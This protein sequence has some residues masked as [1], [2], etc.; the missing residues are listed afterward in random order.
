MPDTNLHPTF[1]A[2]LAPLT[3]ERCDGYMVVSR[4]RLPKSV[5]PPYRYD[6]HYDHFDRENDATEFYGEIES[7]RYNDTREA[8]CI[9][10]CVRGVPLGAKK[11]LP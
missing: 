4:E 9:V 7:G 6:Y 2:I 5:T 8:M 3:V 11:V 1:A 10:P